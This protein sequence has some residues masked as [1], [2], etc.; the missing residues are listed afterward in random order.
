MSENDMRKRK[1]LE[2]ILVQLNRSAAPAGAYV[3]RI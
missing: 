3:E 1:I 2:S